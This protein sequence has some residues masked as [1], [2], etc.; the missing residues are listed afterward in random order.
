MIESQH[1]TPKIIYKDKFEC[2]PTTE[3]ITVEKIVWWNKKKVR[4]RE[5]EK[6]IQ[7]L[8]K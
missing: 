1:T 2:S 3:N 7:L 8:S 5:R 4:E 6:E